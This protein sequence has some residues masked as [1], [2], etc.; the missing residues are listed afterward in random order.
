M[1]FSLKKPCFHE[2]EYQ[3]YENQYKQLQLKYFK[4]VY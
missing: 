3:L 4:L 2:A 1:A